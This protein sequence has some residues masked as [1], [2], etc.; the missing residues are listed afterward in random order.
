MC[1]DRAAHGREQ[2]TMLRLAQVVAS[3]P[4][5]RRVREHIAFDARA[6][7]ERMDQVLLVTEICAGLH[8]AVEDQAVVRRAER[9]GGEAGFQMRAQP[10]IDIFGAADLIEIARADVLVFE[11]LPAEPWIGNDTI[12]GNRRSRLIRQRLEFAGVI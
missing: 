2:Y 7:A 12:G 5:E 9:R 3:G 8:L 10:E 11:R 6:E 1:S 4:V